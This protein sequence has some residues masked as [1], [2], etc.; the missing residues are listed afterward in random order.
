MKS[1]KTDEFIK[2]P[3][4]FMI[5]TIAENNF[6]VIIITFLHFFDP[7]LAC[8]NTISIGKKQHFMMRFLDA[9]TQ[10]IFFAGY[11]FCLLSEFNNFE[12][13]L[14]SFFKFLQDEF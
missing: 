8:R 14:E 11:K 12:A 7:V 1:L 5:P 6:H 3:G 4:T 9:D 13:V 2:N 10:R